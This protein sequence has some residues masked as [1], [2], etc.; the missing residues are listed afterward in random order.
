MPGWHSH[1]VTIGQSVKVAL[2]LQTASSL[3]K[4]QPF[5]FPVHLGPLNVCVASA[6][7]TQYPFTTWTEDFSG[8]LPTLPPPTTLLAT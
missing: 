7:L 1:G 6:V 2:P 4:S 8:C 3:L 5:P